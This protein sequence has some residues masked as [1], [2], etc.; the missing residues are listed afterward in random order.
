MNEIWKIKNNDDVLNAIFF[1]WKT[2]ADIA[3]EIGKTPALISTYAKKFKLLVYEP[4]IENERLSCYSCGS[5]NNLVFKSD[6]KTGKFLA[7]VCRKC[8]LSDNI[9]SIEDNNTNNEIV[10]NLYKEM[11]NISECYKMYNEFFKAIANHYENKNAMSVKEF[12]AFMDTE[13]KDLDKIEQTN[14][15]LGFQ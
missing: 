11:S 4:R 2:Q 14:K 6:K 3:R 9:P 15:R 5:Q 13:I 12:I 1:D 8:I 10:E 7:L